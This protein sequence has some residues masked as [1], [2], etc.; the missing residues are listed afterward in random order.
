MFQEY[1]YKLGKKGSKVKFSD[2]IFEIIKLNYKYRIKKNGD[3][4]Y[5]VVYENKTDERI[6]KFQLLDIL[7]YTNDGRGSNFS[8]TYTVG[9]IN[10]KQTINGVEQNNGNLKLYITNSDSVK[11]M[12]AKNTG[13][14]IDSIWSENQQRVLH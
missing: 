3:V 2:K 6:E 14:G 5:K 1:Q 13:I 11:D 9:S 10:V 7:P 4:K 8:G 12:D